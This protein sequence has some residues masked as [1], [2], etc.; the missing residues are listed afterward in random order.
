MTLATRGSADFSAR[1]IRGDDDG[2]LAFHAPR[3][4]YV[5]EVLAAHGAGT[6]TRVLDIGPSRLTDL[7]RD[8]FG[9]DVDS[10]G[11]RSD[12]ATTRGRH[13]DFDLNRAQDQSTWRTDL[14]GYDVVVM[15]EVLEHL[16]TAPQLV[17]QFVRTLLV[18]DGLLLL[19]TPNAA[20]LSKRIKLLLGW[21]PYEMIRLDASN[22]GHFRE[23][24]RGE[25]RR[26]VT[27]AGLRVERLTTRFYFDMRFERH[28]DEGNAPRPIRGVLKNV[29]YR[30]M[31]APLRWGISL[32]ARRAPD[33]QAP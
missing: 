25:L 13:F 22:P 27:D 21:H 8:R 9:C 5:L 16:Y 30:A 15:A 29:L 32:E 7:I 28:P 31:P 19:Q 3:Y 23:Y 12:R 33:G 6:D 26:L 11:Y 18:P 14:P 4:A 1:A 17:L 20:G 10:L 2:Y 24:T